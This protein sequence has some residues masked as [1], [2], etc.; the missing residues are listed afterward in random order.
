M[1]TGHKLF[2]LKSVILIGFSWC[3]RGSSLLYCY[4]VLPS[5]YRNHVPEKAIVLSVTVYS[6]KLSCQ[7]NLSAAIGLS[8]MFI[9]IINVYIVKPVYKGHSSKPENG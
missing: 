4:H 2:I 8:L 9:Y 6:E 3:L 5:L 1:A 7:C